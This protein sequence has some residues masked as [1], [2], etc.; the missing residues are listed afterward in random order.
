MKIPRVTEGGKWLN[1]NPRKQFV[2]LFVFSYIEQV[3]HPFVAYNHLEGPEGGWQVGILAQ[4][5]EGGW[6][7]DR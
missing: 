5:P 7:L 2:S 6:Q 4:E 1:K 3:Q